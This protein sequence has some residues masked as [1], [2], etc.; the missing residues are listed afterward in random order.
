VRYS[1]LLTEPVLPLQGPMAMNS[2]PVPRSAWHSQQWVLGIREE[3]WMWV[4]VPVMIAN[5]SDCER[6]KVKF[7]ANA[8]ASSHERTCPE[9]EGRN[10]SCW[11]K[12]SANTTPTSIHWLMIAIG[13]ENREEVTELCGVTRRQEMPAENLI[14]H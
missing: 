11:A 10:E 14:L 5:F 6:S 4:G 3:G 8:Y 7:V 2:I 1:F 9:T 13:P 12:Q